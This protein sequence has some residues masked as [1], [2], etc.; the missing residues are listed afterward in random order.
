MTITIIGAS[1]GVGLLS[2]TQALKNGHR[3]TA[4][5]NN[6]SAIPNHAALTKIN[7][8]ATSIQD[9]KRA[10][11]HADAILVTIGT[12]KKKGT[13]LFSDMAKAVIAAMKELNSKSPVLVISGFGVGES[14][15]YTGFVMRMIIKLFLKDQYTDKGLMENLFA[16]SNVKWEM[17]QPGML[18]D[19]ARTKNYKVWPEIEKGMKVGI[20][21]RADLAHYLVSEAQ[22]PQNVKRYV[23]LSY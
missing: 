2:V 22:N 6:T 9:V 4:M 17:V 14:I 1:A 15:K 23:A 11:Q 10:I 19:G 18:T 20:I 12:K 8:S 3:V 5:S 7:G 21:S 16:G 13:A